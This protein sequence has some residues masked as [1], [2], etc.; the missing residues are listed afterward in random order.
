MATLSRD[1][2]RA[3]T[4]FAYVLRELRL[5]QSALRRLELLEAQRI[6]LNY[7]DPKPARVR[8]KQR[9]YRCQHCGAQ[10]WR[11]ETCLFARVEE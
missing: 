3:W 5:T 9:T 6:A 2:Q 10:H 8:H 7:A 4:A 1:A 11:G